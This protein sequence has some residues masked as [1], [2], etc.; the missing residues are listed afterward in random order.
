MISMTCDRC[1]EKR[2][3]FGDYRCKSCRDKYHA[4]WRAENR[5]R[6]NLKSREWTSRNKEK[7]KEIKKK[8]AEA[9]REKLLEKRRLSYRE[10]RRKKGY[11]QNP[12]TKRR[13]KMTYIAR[14][15]QV[16]SE[17]YCPKEILKK[18][19][20]KCVY[21]TNEATCLDHVI[22]LSRGGPDM[23]INLVA[24]CRSCNTSKSNKLLHEWMKT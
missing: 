19:E 7:S 11:K 13:N 6:W 3:K 10:G 24:A 22:P 14:K 1:G 2:I 23:E 16:H 4:E 9:N 18:F 5:D 12:E 20:F 8:Y 21:C 15:L 17:P